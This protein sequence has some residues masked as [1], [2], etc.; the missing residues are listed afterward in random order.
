MQVE[1]LDDGM[2]FFLSSIQSESF[3]TLAKVYRLY[4]DGQLKGQHVPRSK[5]GTLSKPPDLKGSKFKGLRGLDCADVKRLLREVEECT[6]S[7]NELS[8]ECSSIKKLVKVQAAFIKG[9][10]CEDW[11]EATTKYPEYCTPEQLEPF[12]KLNFS[13]TSKTLPDQFLKFC[14]RAMRP[15]PAATNNLPS[16]AMTD[17]VFCVTGNSTCS[18]F[19]RQKCLEATPSTVKNVFETT[20]HQLFQGFS[21]TIFD[22]PIDQVNGNK[23]HIIFKQDSMYALKSIAFQQIIKC[24]LI[25]LNYTCTILFGFTFIACND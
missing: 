15:R 22:I 2:I 5:K 23:I 8:S 19:W 4:A 24:M 18:I 12:A 3:T 16:T 7:L 20:G 13:V 1:Q 14:Q 25:Q 10:N 17:D 9:T 21:L 6:I 11:Q